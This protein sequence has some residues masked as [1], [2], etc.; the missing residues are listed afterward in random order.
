MAD[1]LSI[2]SIPV[3]KLLLDQEKIL[4][5]DVEFINKM[6]TGAVEYLRRLGDLES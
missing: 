3:L 5:G 4:P 1:K 2:L 6:T